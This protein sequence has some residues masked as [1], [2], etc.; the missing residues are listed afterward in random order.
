[1]I[2]GKTVLIGVSGAN[3]QKKRI[4]DVSHEILSIRVNKIE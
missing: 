3:T 2:C 4:K 1:M